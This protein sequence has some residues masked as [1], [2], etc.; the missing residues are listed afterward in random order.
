MYQETVG[1]QVG[2]VHFDVLT[3]LA[4]IDALGASRYN[5][6]FF[7]NFCPPGHEIWSESVHL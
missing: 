1:K 7:A 4:S 5:F 3:S 6:I 2:M